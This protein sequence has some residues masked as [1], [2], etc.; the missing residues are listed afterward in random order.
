MT[1]LS[2]LGRSLMTKHVRALLA[3]L[4]ILAAAPAAASAATDPA[5]LVNPIVGT[6][7]AVDTFPGP[8]MPFGM[9][10]FSPDTAPARPDGGGYEYTAGRIRGFSLTHISGPGCGAYGD[11]PILPTTGALPAD[12][13]G[14]TVPFT[15]DGEV[16][17]A[18]YYKVTAG[19]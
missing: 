7:G 19:D 13:S 8:D 3:A 2:Q 17:R 15:H 5:S 12:P 14:A 4:T 11:V 1:T 18:G 6:S 16:A 9:M 10:Q